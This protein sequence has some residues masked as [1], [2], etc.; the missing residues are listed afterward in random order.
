MQH[1]TPPGLASLLGLRGPTI[2][3]GPILM[4]LAALIL[5]DVVQFLLWPLFYH[6]G[7]PQ[8]LNW[9]LMFF[10]N[11][12]MTGATLLFFRVIRNE[13]A[14]AALATIGYVVVQ[15]LLRVAVNLA[16]Y[17]S[18]NWQPIVLV[19]GLF[20]TFLLFLGLVVCLRWIQ[21]V[22]LALWLG[23]TFAALLGS[24][25]NRIASAI[26]YALIEHMPL[27]VSIGFFDVLSDLLTA[28]VFAFAFWGGL[29]LVAPSPPPA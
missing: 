7:F 18:F 9:A 12:V 1:K 23:A 20:S 4:F 29:K 11:L 14:A 13:F 26:Y 10:A 21:P 19:F 22:L 28:A 2:E 5:S 24:L 8:P 6:S 27:H 15:N 3:F 16:V 17:R 25:L